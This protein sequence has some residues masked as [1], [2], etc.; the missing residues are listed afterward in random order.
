MVEGLV[1]NGVG[2]VSAVLVAVSTVGIGLQLQ[3]IL[4]RRVVGGV[5][6]TQGLSLVRFSTSFLA[7]FSMFLYGLTLEAFNHYLVWP[8]VLA[9]A[10]LLAILFEIWRDRRNGTA[11][12]VLGG[13]LALVAVAVYLSAT[14]YRLV[15]HQAGLTHALVICSALLLMQGGVAQI[16]QIRRTGETGALSLPMHQLFFLKD[17]SSIL[18]AIVMGFANGWPVFA[19]HLVSLVLQVATMWHFRLVRMRKQLSGSRSG[20]NNQNA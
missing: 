14:E 9:L 10:M 20:K 13:G 1:Y 6:A 17:A 7:F 15:V 2:I 16:M 12:A 11:M 3:K 4:K 18:F 19:F 8:R 5:I